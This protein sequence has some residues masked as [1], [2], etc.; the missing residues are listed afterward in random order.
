MNGLCASPISHRSNDIGAMEC[1]PPP[2]RALVALGEELV[3]NDRIIAIIDDDA[4]VRDGVM[5]LIRSMG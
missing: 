5:R 4:L 2:V 3:V 1:R